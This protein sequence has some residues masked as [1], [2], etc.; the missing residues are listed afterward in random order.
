MTL[1]RFALSAVTVGC[2]AFVFALLLPATGAT[3]GVAFAAPHPSQG[4]AASSD[5]DGKKIFLDQ[6]C[7]LCHTVSTAG[8]EAK[9]KSKAMQGPDLVNVG[10]RH[11][12]EWLQ[13]WLRKKVEMNGKKH[14]KAFTGSD[15]ELGALIAW[16]QNQK[17]PS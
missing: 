10:D 12:S 14:R 3:G 2:F 8:I 4:E 5:L 13:G 16:L 17:K 9:V 15:E 7:D 11:D 6:K 1:R